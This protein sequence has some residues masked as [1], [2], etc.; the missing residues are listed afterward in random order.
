[1]AGFH[2]DTFNAAGL[3]RLT[4]ALRDDDS[5]HYVDGELVAI[6][7]GSFGRYDNAEQLID[8]YYVDWDILS[9]VQDWVGPLIQV[10]TSGPENAI[11]VRREIDGY[12]DALIGVG[13]AEIAAAFPLRHRCLGREL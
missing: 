2:A 1:M 7:Q 11:G 9:F 4:L 13:I 8:A 3:N 12:N 6:Y 5:F 10:F